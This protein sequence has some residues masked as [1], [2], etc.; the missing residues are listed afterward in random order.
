MLLKVLNASVGMRGCDLPR[1]S[2]ALKRTLA[3]DPSE[4]SGDGAAK[5]DDISNAA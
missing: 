1:D 5:H 3:S 2:V 4:S